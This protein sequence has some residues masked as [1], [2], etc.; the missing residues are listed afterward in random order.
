[1]G[2]KFLPGER[3]Y[4]RYRNVG[5]HR[6]RVEFERYHSPSSKGLA[7]V[8]G[9]GVAISSLLREGSVVHLITFAQALTVLGIQVL[10]LALLY[11]GTRPQLSGE[12]KVPRW[13]L[14]VASIGFLLSCVLA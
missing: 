4:R 7:L 13:I 14:A 1:M 5:R 10:A 9:M 12:Q 6:K 2:Q 11:L 8:V 3:N